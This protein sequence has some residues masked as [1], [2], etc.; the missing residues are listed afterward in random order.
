MPSVR[1]AA[2]STSTTSQKRTPASRF[3]RRRSTRALRRA[4]WSRYALSTACASSGGTLSGSSGAIS[5]SAVVAAWST[6]TTVYGA[7]CRG[8][9]W[10]LAAGKTILPP[11]S[12]PEQRFSGRSALERGGF[13]LGLGENLTLVSGLVLAVSAFTSWYTVPNGGITVS[14]TGWHTGTIGKLVFFIGLAVL[15]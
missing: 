13:L 12:S 1:L 3:S 9:Q 10:R 4:R 14:V 11:M 5:A 15:L 8:R 2:T 7:R 6:M